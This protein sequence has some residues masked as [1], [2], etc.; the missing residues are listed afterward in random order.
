[1]SLNEAGRKQPANYS[2]IYQA[3][4]TL[5]N[6]YLDNGTVLQQMRLSNLAQIA[7][8][9]AIFGRRPVRISVTARTISTDAFHGFLQSIQAN[10]GIVSYVELV[11]TIVSFHILSSSLSI[12]HPKTRPC[13]GIVFASD[14][15]AKQI[16]TK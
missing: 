9:Q 5:K 3:Q 16:I 10:S 14:S 11:A 1:M 7:A 8:L 6:I 12:D 15:I 4:N 2:A 13:R